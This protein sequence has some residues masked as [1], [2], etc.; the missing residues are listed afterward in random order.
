MAACDRQTGVY[1][2]SSHGETIRVRGT[3]PFMSANRVFVF[4]MDGVLVASEKEWVMTEPR[5]LEDMFGENISRA[6]GDTVGISIGQIYEKAI[7]LGATMDKQ[8]FDRL[9]NEKAIRGESS[10]TRETSITRRVI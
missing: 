4:D 5:M 7:R 3:I 1:I 10:I 6:I 2:S 8:E 9:Y